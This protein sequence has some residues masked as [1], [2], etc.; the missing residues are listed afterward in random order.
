M[1]ELPGC[2]SALSQDRRAETE[3]VA[4]TAADESTPPAVLCLESVPDLLPVFVTVLYITAVLCLVS[5]LTGGR[6]SR[7]DP[8]LIFH[9]QSVDVKLS[10]T[11]RILFC[12]LK[13]EIG[14]G[15]FGTLTELC[16]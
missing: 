14:K 12:T 8:G 6:E 16:H 13:A 5:S 1:A 11:Q 2:L 3:P 10:V 15:P 7:R 9:G 4:V